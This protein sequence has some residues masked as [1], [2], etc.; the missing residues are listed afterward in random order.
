MV[1][2]GFARGDLFVSKLWHAV[3]L[4]KYPSALSLVA[5]MLKPSQRAAVQ[6]WF[7]GARSVISFRESSS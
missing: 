7:R 4:T 2:R 3:I 1:K 6:G 5:K